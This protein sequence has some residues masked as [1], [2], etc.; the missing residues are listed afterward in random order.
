MA[1][2]GA[3]GLAAERDTAG[4]LVAGEPAGVEIAALA[5]GI[6][7]GAEGA[8]GEGHGGDELGRFAEDQ[9]GH[10]VLVPGVGGALGAATGGEKIAHFGGELRR[11]GFAAGWS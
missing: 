9:G 10:V 5:M 2:V 11:R 3:L 4:E 6:E 8:A 7:G 1:A